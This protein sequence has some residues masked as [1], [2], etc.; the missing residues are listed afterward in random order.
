MGCGD[1][2][3]GGLTEEEKRLEDLTGTWSVANNGSTSLDTD[4][5]TADWA[6]FSLTVNGTKTYS[7][8]GSNDENVWPSTGSFDFAGTDGA[9]L[10]VINRS[11]GVTITIDVISPTN[12]DLSFTYVLAKPNKEGRVQSIEGDWEFKLTR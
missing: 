1:D 12:L 11:D 7:T 3:G 9:G 8:T 2:G 10:D 6:N 4:D 5:R